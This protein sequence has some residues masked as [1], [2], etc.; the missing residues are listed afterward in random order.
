RLAFP[1]W[2]LVELNQARRARHAV[3]ALVAQGL[4]KA[5]A[6]SKY[7]RTMQIWSGMVQGHGGLCSEMKRYEDWVGQAC[8]IHRSEIL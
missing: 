3:D 5:C 6:F 4:L 7:H 8:L 1:Q 2:T